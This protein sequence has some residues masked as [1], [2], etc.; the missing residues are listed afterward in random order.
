MKIR[1]TNALQVVILLVFG[2]L[3]LANAQTV[4][5]AS[6]KAQSKLIP[7]EL[8]KIFL[9]MGFA[10][11]SRVVDLKDA[12]VGDIRFEWLEISIPLRKARVEKMIV[13]IHGLSV[14]D[15]AEILTGAKPQNGQDGRQIDA[16]TASLNIDRI[17][18][19]GFVYAIYVTFVSDFDLKNYVISTYGR[20]G[21]VRKPDDEYRF[22]DI[23]WTKKTTDGITW[24]IRSFHEGNSRDLQLLGRIDGT[25]WGLD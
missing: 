21:D 19:K 22:Y 14:E 20:D 24:L 5:N 18:A 10:E 4:A 23:Q 17:P 13:R 1:I 25:E 16:D 15:K 3:V 8:G 12:S 9:G 11:F 7:K 6:Y 2:N